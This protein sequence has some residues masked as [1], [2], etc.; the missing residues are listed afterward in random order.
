MIR[1]MPEPHRDV[2]VGPAA[3]SADPNLAHARHQILNALNGLRLS[4]DALWAADD[5]AEA[6]EWLDSL[7][8]SAERAERAVDLLDALAP[9]PSQPPA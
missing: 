2:S 3:A 4:V 5:D 9:D 7:I 8:R 6:V 1:R